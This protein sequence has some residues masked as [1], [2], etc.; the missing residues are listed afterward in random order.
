MQFTLEDLNSRSYW[1]LHEEQSDKYSST[2]F[3]LLTKLRDHLRKA[4]LLANMEICFVR[5]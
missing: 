3:P 2:Q 1:W 4:V 5:W